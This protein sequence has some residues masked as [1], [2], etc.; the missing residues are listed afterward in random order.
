V[1]PHAALKSD[2]H[3]G[4]VGGARDSFPQDG[5]LGYN[6]ALEA[7]ASKTKPAKIL[8]VMIKDKGKPASRMANP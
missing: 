5:T 4:G 8:V 3:C 6:D 2:G 1:L 7:N